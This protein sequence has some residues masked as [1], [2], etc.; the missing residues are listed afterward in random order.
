MFFCNGKNGMCDEKSCT[1]NYDL[2][3]YYSGNG[4]ETLESGNE[5]TQEIIEKIKFCLNEGLCSSCCFGSSKPILTC[6]V[7]L[8]EILKILGDF[9]ETKKNR[10]D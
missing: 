1:K 8:E 5:K 6:K 4:G 10:E 3:E 7:L 9:S 2:C